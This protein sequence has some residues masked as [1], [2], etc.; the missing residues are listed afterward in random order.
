MD[1]N[2]EI[3]DVFSLAIAFIRHTNQNLFI[4]GRAGTGKT[5]FLKKIKGETNKKLVVAA[6]TGIA[7][8]H[9]E[10]TTLNALFQVPPGLYLPGIPNVIEIYDPTNVVEGLNYSPVKKN[11]LRQLE[12]LI[13]DEVSMVR[14]DQVDLMDQILRKVRRSNLPFGGIQVVF[15]GDP[16]QLPP[17]I[18]KEAFNRFNQ[19]YSSPYFFEANVLKQNPLIQIEFTKIFRQLDAAFIDVLNSVRDNTVNEKTLAILN[20]RYTPNFA[21]AP[22]E[23]FI[24]ITSHN[25]EA[26]E[27]NIRRLD[28]L[29]GSEYSFDAEIKGDFPEYLF[30]IDKTLRLKPG[31]QVMFIKNDS[32]PDRNFFNGK[33]GKIKSIRDREILVSFSNKKDFRVERATWY[34]YEYKGSGN[35]NAIER[36][37]VGEFSQYPLKLAWAATIHK[38]QGLTFEQA[39]ID[40][41]KSFAP[42]QVYVALSRVKSLQGLILLSAIT[43]DSIQ[44]SK[45]IISYLN[46]LSQNQLWERL[47]KSQLSYFINLLLERFSLFALLEYLDDLLGKPMTFKQKLGNQ[48]IDILE[49]IQ[50]IISELE[51]TRGRFRDKLEESA[52][53]LDATYLTARMIN[54]QQYFAKV[55][56]SECL[57]KLNELNAKLTGKKPNASIQSVVETIENFFKKQDQEVKVGILLAKR[58]EKGESVTVLIEE[59][60]NQLVTSEKTQLNY[61]NSKEVPLNKS[62][63][64]T[65][66]GIRAGKQLMQI[67]NERKLALNTIES[68]VIKAVSL[69]QL[70]AIDLV[71]EITFQRINDVL[72]EGLLN[73]QDVVEKLG[74]GY[75][76]LE[77]R[78]VIAQNEYNKAN[79]KN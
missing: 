1:E 66:D 10:G 39:I 73:V 12:V 2:N 78:A 43:T 71:S 7:A 51:N 59:N 63:Q 58:F 25:A 56:Q 40:A 61:K 4:T 62:V 55:I 31:A 45:E 69:G 13:V 36:V 21:P 67:S 8:I 50:G 28:D 48:T 29:P 18:K 24:T 54:A 70:K 68:H 16:F 44:T 17:V 30:P 23:E 41:G 79:G 72:K 47:T 75:S 14:C 60:R 65:I 77:I 3:S 46:P 15:I 64:E 57:I 74:S 38:S 9:A 34:A 53:S 33:I 37:S 32:G 27:I 22:N 76:F 26:N 42:G 35:D 52:D 11:L 19:V 5:T 49:E 20:Q 6:P